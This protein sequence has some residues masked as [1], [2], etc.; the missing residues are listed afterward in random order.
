MRRY[1]RIGVDIAKNSFQ[2]HA[3]ESEDCSATKRRLSRSGIVKFL[4]EVEPCAIGMEAC[5]SAHYWA[6][7]VCAMGHP[8]K[9]TPAI[10]LQTML[11][12]GKTTPRE[13]PAAAERTLR[14]TIR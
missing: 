9:T 12:A 5:G 7:R 14:P 10:F 3:L 8:G 6:R 1:I 2:V 13:P 4:A 11:N